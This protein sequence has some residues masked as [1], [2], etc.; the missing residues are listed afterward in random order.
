[1]TVNAAAPIASLDAVIPATIVTAAVRGHAHRLGPHAGRV[2]NWGAAATAT[3]VVDRTGPAVAGCL[4]G[5][6]PNNGPSAQP[7]A[8]A[9]RR[10]PSLTDPSITA[11]RS[12]VIEAEAFIDTVGAN[13]SGIPLGASDGALQRR[14]GER[15]PRHPAADRHGAEHRARTR[16]SVHAKDAAGNWGAMATTSLVVDKIGPALSGL[17]V[18][19][20]PTPAAAPRTLTGTATDAAPRRPGRVVS[21]HR[22][23]RGN[24]HGHDG[25]RHR[26]RPLIGHDRRR[27][28]ATR[29]ATR[30]RPRQRRRRQLERASSTVTLT[31][32][33]PA[34]LLHGRQHQ[35]AGRGRHG[36]R[37]RHLQLERHGLQPRRSTRARSPAPCRRAN[38][39]GFSRVDATHF[40][41]SFTGDVTVP[42]LGDGP[43]RGRR[44]LATAPWQLFFDGTAHGLTART[45]TSTPSASSG[46]TL[47]FSTVGNTNPPGR[48]RGRRRRRHLLLERHDATPACSTPRRTASR[49]PRT[50]TATSWV[51]A[52]HFYL[53]FAPTPRVPGL[54]AVQ[55]EDVVRSTRARGRSTST[56]PP[57]A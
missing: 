30:C 4:G 12:T 21:G 14:H 5:P 50:S 22:P 38:V 11:A 44:V 33:G 3:F 48:G 34:H 26:A 29:A 20:N 36:R 19:P 7:Q 23:R 17:S 13:G 41:L 52:T 27:G 2:G 55:D 32:R 42:G 45:S 18:T 51:D 56:A 28:P 24:A 40:Y 15:L 37:R 49:P 9:V 1:M 47:Y 35:P 16:I 31:V 46:S 57:T 43:G 25:H 6:D 8:S 53:S 39:D 54:G 10:R